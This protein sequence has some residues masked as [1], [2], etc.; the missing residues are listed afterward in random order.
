MIFERNACVKQ[1]N[2]LTHADVYFGRVAKI[3]KERKITKDKTMR[4]RRSN[5]IMKKLLF[6]RET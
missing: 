4:Q 5:Y 2:N 3:S 6:T 1:M